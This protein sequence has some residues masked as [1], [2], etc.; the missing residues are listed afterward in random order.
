MFNHGT[1]F[2][3]CHG[4]IFKN[5]VF[6]RSS[7]IQNKFTANDG[8]FSATR[9][10]TDGQ[11]HRLGTGH[12]GLGRKRGFGQ[13]SHLQCRARG[14]QLLWHKSLGLV[15]QCKDRRRRRLRPERNDNESLGL[16]PDRRRGGRRDRVEISDTVFQEPS[17]PVFLAHLGTTRDIGGVYFKDYRYIG[18]SGAETRLLDRREREQQRT[19]LRG[20]EIDH[21]Q[22]FFLRSLRLRR[23]EA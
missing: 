17:H 19:E 6:L 4:V 22:R 10:A 21:G 7:S 11:G 3:N 1:Y 18:P 13:R 16:L 23:A 14:Q 8:P 5:N 2:E 9:I 20:L 12:H 15:P